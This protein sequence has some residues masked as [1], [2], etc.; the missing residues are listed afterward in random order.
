MKSEDIRD[1]NLNQDIDMSVL[2]TMMICMFL[3]VWIIS[4][5]DIMICINIISEK[6][7]GVKLLQQE[8]YH[9][10]EHFINLLTLK[11]IFSL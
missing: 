2:F 3:E 10:Q 8:L 7:N 1:V 6:D 5:F 9:R 11:I 4:K